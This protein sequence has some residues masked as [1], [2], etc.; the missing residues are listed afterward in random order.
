MWS[1]LNFKSKSFVFKSPIADHIPSI[2]A[3]EINIKLPDQVQK[4][5]D[6]SQTKYNIFYSK[7]ESEI[8]HLRTSIN[9]LTGTGATPIEKRIEFIGKWA[10]KKC[11]EFFPIMQRTVSQ[12]RFNSPWL[13]SELIGFINKKHRLFSLLRENKLSRDTY[14]LYCNKLKQLLNLCENNYH[15]N[16]LNAYKYDG[17]KKWKHINS[18]MGRTAD[19]TINMISVNDKPI[20]QGVEVANVFI[21]E[22]LNQRLELRQQ[23]PS[24]DRDFNALIPSNPNSLFF[25][26]VHAQEISN[27]IL[28]LKNNSSLSEIPT[29]FLKLIATYLAPI[30]TDIIND[31]FALGYYPPFLKIS[32][33]QPIFKGGDRT[34]SKNY[35]GIT[36]GSDLNKIFEKTI[37]SRTYSFFDHNG[38][39]S[40]NQFGFLKNK[41][42]SQAAIQLL[43][44]GISALKKEN[45]TIAVAL[46]LSKAF[47]CVDHG[48]LLAKL[49]KYGVRGMSLEIIQSYLSNRKMKVRIGKHYSDEKPIPMDLGVPQ[50]SCLGPLFYLIYANDIHNIVEGVNIV[51]YADDILLII[52]GDNLENMINI[53]N[54]NLSIISEWCIFNYLTIN[55]NKSQCIIFSNRRVHITVK[56][57]LNGKIIDIVS[58]VSYLGLHL[59]NKLNFSHQLTHVNNKLSQICGIAWKITRKFNVNTAK[60]YYYAFAFSHLCYGISAWGG[61]LLTYNCSKT[62]SLHKRIV[63]NL[64]SW[65]FPYDDYASICVKMGLLSVIDIYKLN[66]MVLFFNITKNNF[67]PEIGFETYDNQYSLRNENEFRVPFPRTT[68]LTMHFNYR[69]PLIWNEIPLIIRNLDSVNKFKYSYKKYLLEKFKNSL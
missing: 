18:L 60:V 46:D 24:S 3:F 62:F 52:N 29:K 42:T 45:F 37:Y 38:L 47:D 44:N 53:I 61:V 22:F 59:E 14:S 9:E 16:R 63:M 66:L 30:L 64:F 43:N 6:F 55:P 8:F 34:S 40:R 15:K 7:I 36:I 25:S 27:I 20:T 50:G 54:R 26:P 1:N 32:T 58:V 28:Q 23:I 56:I 67:L 68:V 19:N 10:S 57:E 2:S 51:S 17:R 5:R 31:C 49:Q 35:R 69:M 33:T 11:N 65:H 48:N 13:T 39:I 41:S 4:F 21:G 12:K